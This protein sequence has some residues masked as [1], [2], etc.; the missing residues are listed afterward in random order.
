[1]QPK[2]SGDTA[3]LHRGG[4][5]LYNAQFGFIIREDALIALAEPDIEPCQICKPETGLADG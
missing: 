2:R 5:G 4:C 1:M 3:L